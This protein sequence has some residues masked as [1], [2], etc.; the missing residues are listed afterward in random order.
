MK[1]H[2][3]EQGRKGERFIGVE[4]QA[5]SPNTDPSGFVILH[6][7]TWASHF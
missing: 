4:I 6:E 3:N 1:G 2:S 7:L 5:V